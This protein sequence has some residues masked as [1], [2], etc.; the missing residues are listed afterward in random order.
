MKQ[1]PKTKK[2]KKIK[3]YHLHRHIHRHIK[4]H[5]ARLKKNH[6][7]IH[8]VVVLMS[9]TLPLVLGA[10]LFGSGALYLFESYQDEI[11]NSNKEKI[12]VELPIAKDDTLS[13]KTHKEDLT[14]FTVKYFN[15]WSDP[16][17]K[18]PSSDTKYLRKI[19]FDN[20]LDPSDEKYKGFDVLIYDAK[21]YPGPV[22][23][24][25]LVEKSTTSA[26]DTC[27]KAEFDSATVGEEDYPAQEVNILSKNRCFQEAFFYS[28]TKG[29]YTYNIVPL[30]G[31][32]SNPIA[33]GKKADVISA[34]P[35][36]F[37]ILSTITLPQ[38]EV[39]EIE[40]RSAVR[41]AIYTPEVKPHRVLITKAMCA[42]KNDHPRKSKTKGHHMDEDCCMDPDE[43][44]NPRCQY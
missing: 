44:P 4:K 3:F 37:E 36:F 21:R 5:L 29:N 23:T 19:T 31:P 27:D 43:S 17:V 22:G 40:Q 26:D 42:H 16:V 38:I 11:L 28:V 41:R 30:I 20:G 12:N 7:H 1:K 33:D 10:M 32:V 6:R 24:G 2:A 13:W 15:F 8:K 25:S 18:K 39:K 34:F 14:G 35:K 9:I